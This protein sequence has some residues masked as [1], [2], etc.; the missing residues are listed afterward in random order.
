[1]SDFLWP[2]EP[3]H[4]RPPC[5]SPTPGVY[6]NS[7]PSSR[8]CYPT[9]STS[10]IPFSCLQSCPATRSFLMSQFFAWGGQSIGASASVSVLPRNTQDQSPLGRTGW[11][12]LQSVQGTLKSPLDSRE[13]K[14]VHPKGNQFWIFTGRT[15]AEAEA[16]ILWPPH[17]KS[18]LTERGPEAGKDWR[19]EKGKTEDEM[20]GWHHRLNGHEFE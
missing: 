19:W 18:L 17:A 3:Q 9:I 5:P 1:M 11:I 7:C 6:P 12:S 16:P 14:P 4:T 13:F 10:V 8:W 20:V 2:H 15:D